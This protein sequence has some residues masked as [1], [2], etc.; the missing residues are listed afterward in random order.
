MPTRPSLLLLSVMTG[1]TAFGPDGTIP[2]ALHKD[3]VNLQ[4]NCQMS[5]DEW[6]EKCGEDY[7]IRPLEQRILCPSECRP[8]KRTKD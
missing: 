2:M 3:M 7:W 6:L 8:A 4:R 1:C 5:D